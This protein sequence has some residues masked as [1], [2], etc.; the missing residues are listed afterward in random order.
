V[1]AALIAGRTLVIT[2]TLLV[3]FMIFVLARNFGAT[4]A[5]SLIAALAFLC[6]PLLEPWGFEFRVDMPALAFGITALWVFW[7]GYEFPAVLL[8]VLSFFCKQSSGE[9][10]AAI[11]LFLCFQ[12]K[13]GR[14]VALASTWLG[15]VIALTVLFEWIWPFYLL[16]TFTAVGAGYLDLSAPSDA[17]FSIF[18]LEI[19]LAILAAAAIISRR[20][21]LLPMLFLASALLNNLTGMF[22]WGANLYYFL[23]TVAAMSIVAA[24]QL[25]W[26][27]EKVAHLRWSLAVPCAVTIG[28]ALFIC[29]LKGQFHRF[30]QSPIHSISPTTVYPRSIDQNSLQIVDSIDG[31]VL[32]D[33]PTVLLADPS[34]ELRPINLMVLGGMKANGLFDD[35]QLLEE[36]RC[37]RFAAFALDSSLLNRN[38]RGRFFFWPKLRQAIEANYE[39][40]APSGP[41]FVMVP[42]P[43]TPCP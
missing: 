31:P 23:P 19:P 41:P 13:L 20:T 38:Y 43:G 36:I 34:P 8:C 17:L 26:L 1:L 4:A 33:E 18:I 3:S 6:S 28:A 7:K 27:L 9:A 12:G 24:P 5:A 15:L 40:A 35:T 25:D 10:M 14:A 30:L 42:K 2:S 32:A 22:R 11:V 16:S 39:L 29:N 21:T 37:R